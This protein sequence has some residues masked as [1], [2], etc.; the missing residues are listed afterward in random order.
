MA[1]ARE[2][3]AVVPHIGPPTLL[4]AC[5]WNRCY[6]NSF[7]VAGIPVTGRAS[8]WKRETPLCCANQATGSG[9]RSIPGYCRRSLGE[10][11]RTASSST[12]LALANGHPLEAANSCATA[13]RERCQ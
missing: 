1:S 12:W 4:A 8:P 2:A 13:S 9:A 3:P 7:P 10:G 5:H 6:C 11:L